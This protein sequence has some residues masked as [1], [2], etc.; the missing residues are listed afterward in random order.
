MANRLLRNVQ[1]LAEIPSLAA[2][3][4][5]S[6][7]NINCNNTRCATLTIR[8]TFN[9]SATAGIKL[10]AYYSADGNNYDT[11]AYATFTLNL[12]AGSTVQETHIFDMPEEGYIEL[13]VE[14]SDSTY[15]ATDIRLWYAYARYGD[16]FVE[17]DKVVHLLGEIN[18]HL[19]DVG[20]RLEAIEK[21]TD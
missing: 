10:N 4:E 11:V 8:G 16:Q 20:R 17:G 15:T 12:S 19:L 13:K 14:N 2:S 21:L 3:G 7:G 18:K 9:A 5:Y 1:Q 6:V